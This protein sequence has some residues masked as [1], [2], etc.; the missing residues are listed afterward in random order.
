MGSPMWVPCRG[1]GR[2]S[3]YSII[4][5]ALFT[6]ESA[7][8][9]SK[10]HWWMCSSCQENFNLFSVSYTI[11]VRMWGNRR[12]GPNERGFVLK[13]RS[14][15]WFLWSTYTA[16]RWINWMFIWLWY[17]VWIAEYELWKDF[18]FFL[19]TSP[20]KTETRWGESECTHVSFIEFMQHIQQQV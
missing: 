19:W 6:L 2:K 8:H 9:F 14:V 13:L 16:S 4:A 18:F 1:A 15:K 10:P 7:A 17:N 3:T 11:I 20:L 5:L 12:G